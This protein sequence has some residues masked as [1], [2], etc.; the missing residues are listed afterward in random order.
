MKITLW[1]AISLNGI[2]ATPENK[3][4]FLSHENWIEFVKAV[5]KRGCLIW[6][7][8]TYEIVRTW[9]AS[10]LEP[11]TDVVKVILSRD[12]TLSLDSGYTLAGSPSQAINILKE[13]GFRE[14][15]LTGG[16]QNN[17]AFAKQGLIDEMII[18]LEGVVVGRGIPLF[19][20]EDFVLPLQL[21]QA[22]KITSN[23]LQ[24]HYRVDKSQTV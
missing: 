18:N 14:A 12:R 3:E 1:M 9:D 2:I 16:S 10:Y 17:T 7:R 4:D 20:P 24:L 21:M 15:I 23:I 13:N 5:K 22:K 8:K 11:F 6:G 19:H